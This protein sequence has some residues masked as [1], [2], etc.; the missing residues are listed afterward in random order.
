MSA[1]SRLR[2]FHPRRVA[3]KVSGRE[4][5][6]AV[7]QLRNRVD[8]MAERTQVSV[9]QSLAASKA[10]ELYTREV[11]RISPQL[12]ALETKVEALRLALEPVPGGDADELAEARS[13]VTA[14]QDEHRRIRVRLSALSQYEERL[15]RIEEKLGLPH[16]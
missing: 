8:G 2:R 11:N 3:S 5:M 15:R 14:I 16:D 9:Q 4:A 13:I 10:A 12:A 1:R 7:D 6:G